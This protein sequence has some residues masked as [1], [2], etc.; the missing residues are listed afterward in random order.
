MRNI[1]KWLDR[2]VRSKAMWLSAIGGGLVTA[3][4]T[5]GILQP[6]LPVNA[7]ATIAI[8]LSVG[9]AI[10]RVFTDKPLSDK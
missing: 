2:C 10:I 3:E 4:A 5:L 1:K 6:F 9:G 8:G 7:Y